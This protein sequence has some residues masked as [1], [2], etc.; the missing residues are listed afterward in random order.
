MAPKAANEASEKAR[1][2]RPNTLFGVVEVQH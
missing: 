1:P 2:I